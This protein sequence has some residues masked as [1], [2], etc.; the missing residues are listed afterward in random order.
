MI[1]GVR[2]TAGNTWLSQTID[3]IHALPGTAIDGFALHA[4][5]NPFA[6]ASAAIQERFDS[7]VSQLAV[8]DDHGEQG[9]AV[10][11]TEWARS[12]STSGN[13]AANK[14]VTADLHSWIAGRPARLERS[15]GNHNVVSL[16]W[17]V[18]NKDYGSWNEYSL[19]YWKGLGN[20]VGQAGDL[21]TAFQESS[22]YYP[23]GLKGT[24]PRRAVPAS[25]ISTTMAP[26]MAVIFYR[27]QRSY[28]PGRWSPARRRRRQR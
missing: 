1:P 13:V 11:I 18:H 8:I 26:L 16:S 23:A 3:A 2:W 17:F 6:S 21:W 9:T 5:G 19:E 15:T 22:S 27:W 7:Y 12:T 14:S 4:Y 24:R 28:N 25:V 10:Y 20:P